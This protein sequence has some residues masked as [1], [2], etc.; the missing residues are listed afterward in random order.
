M[1]RP[2]AAT[3]FVNAAF[4][5]L[6]GTEYEGAGEA[7]GWEVWRVARRKIVR[8]A[9]DDEML[10][11]TRTFRSA[12][13]YLLLHTTGDGPDRRWTVHTWKGSDASMI[14]AGFAGARPAPERKPFREASG[15]RVARSRVC[16]VPSRAFGGVRARSF[17]PIDV[18]DAGNGASKLANALAVHAG[19]GAVT[20]KEN[21]GGDECGEFLETIGDFLVAAGG[22]PGGNQTSRCSVWSGRAI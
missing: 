8:A 20:K 5:N 4:P 13:V 6:K 12:D 7:E 22:G 1:A 21:L 18:S 9:D 16:T 2:R 10:E 15:R 17:G 19:G 11:T 14:S 3:R